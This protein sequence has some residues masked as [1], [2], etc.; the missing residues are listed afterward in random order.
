MVGRVAAASPRALGSTR[1]RVD[2]FRKI[3]W[4]CFF[5]IN[6][7]RLWLDERGCLFSLFPCQFPFLVVPAA[8]LAGFAYFKS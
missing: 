3:S 4:I 1:K 8:G 6:F 7:D 5:S 2:A